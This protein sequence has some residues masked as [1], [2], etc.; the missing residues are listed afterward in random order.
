MIAERRVAITRRDGLS[1]LPLNLLAV[2]GP[3]EFTE[4]ENRPSISPALRIVETDLAQSNAAIFTEVPAAAPRVGSPRA[5]L[6]LP[7]LADGQRKA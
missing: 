5:P 2:R 1:G 3:V 4:D 6:R 7:A